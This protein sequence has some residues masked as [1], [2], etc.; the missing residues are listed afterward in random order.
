M[1]PVH[2]AYAVLLGQRGGDADLSATFHEPRI[3]GQC[4]DDS[5]AER[6]AFAIGKIKTSR[7]PRPP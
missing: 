4:G 5:S 3:A 6:R 2:I 7:L 1:F